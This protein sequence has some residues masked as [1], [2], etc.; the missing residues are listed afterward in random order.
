MPCEHEGRDQGDAAGMP[1]IAIK[2]PEAG[3]RLEKIIH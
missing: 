3:Q 2:Q 1:E